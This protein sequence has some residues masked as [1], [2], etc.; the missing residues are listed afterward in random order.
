MFIL[1]FEIKTNASVK[2]LIECVERNNYTYI[3]I[4]STLNFFCPYS[5]NVRVLA[6]Y[7]AILIP[8]VNVEL[9]I[10]HNIFHYYLFQLHKI[11]EVRNRDGFVHNTFIVVFK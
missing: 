10:G 2:I 6:F 3:N 7:R 4:S 11:H 9:F 1:Y 8:F 5:R